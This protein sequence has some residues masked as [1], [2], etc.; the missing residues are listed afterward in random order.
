[1]RHQSARHQTRF[2]FELRKCQTK[3]SIAEDQRLALAE[4]ARRVR[5]EGADGDVTEG[6][7]P[8]Y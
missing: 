7:E 4:L 1:M 5:E 8:E 6:H 2:C 3:V